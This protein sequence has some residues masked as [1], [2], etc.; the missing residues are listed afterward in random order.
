MSTLPCY[1]DNAA[2]SFPKPRSVTDEVGRCLRTYC[3]NAGRGGHSLSLAAA[4]KIYDCRVAAADL[5]GLDTPE[6]IVFVPNATYG[7][8]LIIKGLL[9]YG[10]HVIISDMEHNSVYRPLCKLAERGEI[11]LDIFPALSLGRDCSAERICKGIIELIKPSTRL[12]LCNHQSNIC[13]FAL[14]IREIGELCEKHGII[15]ALD[16]AQSAGHIPIDMKKQHVNL[17]CAPGHKGLY[18]IQGSG[19]VAIRS[20]V[21]L[22]TLIEGGNGIQSLSPAMPDFPPERY[23]AGTLSTPC[24]AG[25]CEGIMEIGRIGIDTISQSEEELF[26]YLREGLENTRGVT[27]YAGE[28]AGSTLSFNIDGFPS[29]KVAYILDKRGICVRS[30]FH[31]APLAHKALKTPPDGTIRASFGIFNTKK[32]VDRLLLACS[33]VIKNK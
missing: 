28:H 6:N 18:G 32:D 20:E 30:G 22:D 25:L 19:F 10:D 29:D 12:I 8:N 11:T 33:D 7:L 1:L 26:I 13:S 5:V 3:G 24:I 15:F 27:V 9:H 23:E 2:T 14:P 4:N 16:A 21:L 31:C 17:L